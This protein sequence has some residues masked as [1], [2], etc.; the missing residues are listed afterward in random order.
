[1]SLMTPKQVANLQHH[2]DRTVKRLVATALKALERCDELDRENR[3]LQEE[4]A[5]KEIERPPILIIADHKGGILVKAERYQPV[6][7]VPIHEADSRNQD[8]EDDDARARTPLSHRHLWDSKTIATGH[9]GLDRFRRACGE[10][11]LSA[12]ELLHEME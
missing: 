2:P 9:T 12:S 6:K 7:V 5:V 1:M 4:Q 3:R 10:A 8:E 11:V